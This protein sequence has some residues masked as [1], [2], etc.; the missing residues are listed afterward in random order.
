MTLFLSLSSSL[1]YLGSLGALICDIIVPEQM[2][3]VP[4]STSSRKKL[5]I[6][7]AGDLTFRRTTNCHRDERDGSH[8]TRLQLDA[9]K[10]NR[11]KGR[12][13]RWTLWR[14]L[15]EEISYLRVTP[16]PWNFKYFT[17]PRGANNTRRCFLTNKNYP[18]PFII[19]KRKRE[20]FSVV[21]SDT[22]MARYFGKM[23]FSAD[24]GGQWKPRCIFWSLDTI[25]VDPRD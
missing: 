15:E 13:L 10:K 23:R 24:M 17:V 18:N 12:A 22:L 3:Q 21:T 6:S 2:N 16:P 14:K 4:R 11:R 20:R 5:K 19:T 25:I 1:L 9:E 8:Q 7:V